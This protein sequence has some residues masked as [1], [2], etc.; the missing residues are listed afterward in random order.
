MDPKGNLY[1]NCFWDKAGHDVRRFKADGMPDWTIPFYRR[2]VAGGLGTAVATDGHY[3]FTALARQA[4]GDRGARAACDHIRRLDAATGAPANFP[5][6]SDNLI[7]VNAEPKPWFPHQRLGE[8]DSGRLFGVRGLAVDAERLWVSNHT[9]GRVEGYDK[10][11]G[12]KLGEFVVNKPLG[13]AVAAAGTLWVANNGDRVTQFT[14]DGRRR[15]EITGLKDPYA[16]AV[17]GP[18]RHLYV[19]GLGAG[20]IREY[21][22]ETPGPRRKRIAA[23]R[24]E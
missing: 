8:E 5:G 4:K 12:R 21:A 16:V 13:L 24:L 11:A 2:N 1:Q 14:P 10:E 6:V 9:A 22:L 7:V 17:G 18:D 15:G 3:V 23:K 20:C 19:T